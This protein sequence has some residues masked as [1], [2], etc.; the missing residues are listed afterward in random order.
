MSADAASSP[1]QLQILMIL[2]YYHPHLTGLTQ[3]VRALAEAL[4]Q[5]GHAVTVLAARHSPSLPA[6]S[7]RIN[8]VRVV[9]LWAPISISRGLLMPGYPLA[10]WQLLRQQDIVSIHT[11]LLETAL[12]AWM[13]ERQGRPVVP[14]HHGDLIMPRGLLNR[15]ITRTMFAFY[16]YM[17]RRAA[18]IVGYSDDYAEHS[19][20]LQPFRDKVRAI[21]P[22]VIIPEPQPACVAAYRAQWQHE[23]GPLIGYSGRFVQ[24]KRPD[25]LIR[26]LE[27]INRKYPNARIV[28]AGETD[29]PYEDTWQQQQPLVQRFAPQLRFLGLLQDKQELAN[30]YAAC[31]LL[32]LPSDSECF[33]LVQAEAMLCGTPV[34]MTD[35]PGGRVPVQVTGMGRLARA[36]DWRSMGAAIVAI[37]D[38]LPAYTKPKAF[39]AELF[40]FEK[41]VDAYERLFRERA[42]RRDD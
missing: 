29:I 14:T 38:D 4:V 37:L 27:I 15:L 10:L 12:V 32:A 7:E 35:I 33:G 30:F 22:P 6:G 16:S 2:T 1:R 18:A 11:P 34:M 23:G 41:T 39:I 21:M 28:F 19:Y 26:A 13:A 24:E 42:R 36:G 5:R 40:S 25:L 9:R 8:G 20:Y 31:D 17:A 3:H